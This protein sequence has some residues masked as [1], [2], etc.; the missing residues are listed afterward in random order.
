MMNSY[1]EFT[2]NIHSSLLSNEATEYVHFLEVISN[3]IWSIGTRLAVHISLFR[4]VHKL[5]VN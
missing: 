1:P 2:F 4:G 5:E 3:A